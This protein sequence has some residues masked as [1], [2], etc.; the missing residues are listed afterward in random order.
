MKRIM[1]VHNDVYYR[2][3]KSACKTLCT[4]GYTKVTKVRDSKLCIV[5]ILRYLNIT[6]LC[7]LEYKMFHNAIL[8]VYSIHR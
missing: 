5:T 6:I 8:H 7:R 4:I 2:F 3:A 1:Q